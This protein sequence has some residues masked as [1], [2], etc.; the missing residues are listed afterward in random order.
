MSDFLVNQGVMVSLATGISALLLQTAI[1]RINPIRRMLHIP[2]APP[3]RY[4]RLPTFRE[5][6]QAAINWF[7]QQK[8]EAAAASIASNRRRDRRR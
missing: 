3:Q 6:F 4:G 8:K 2:V 7:G 5:T 1:L